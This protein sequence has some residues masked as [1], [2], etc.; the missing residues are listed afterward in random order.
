[1]RRMTD[2]AQGDL[3]QTDRPTENTELPRVPYTAFYSQALRTSIR[4]MSEIELRI[5]VLLATYANDEGVCWPGIRE[6]AEQSGYRAEDVM[7]ALEC[8]EAAGK[9][10][11]LRRSHRDPLTRQM[12]PNVYAVNPMLVKAPNSTSMSEFLLIMEQFQISSHSRNS[13]QNHQTRISKAASSNQHQQAP[14]PTSSPVKAN[15][16]DHAASSE[17]AAG[18][19]NANAADAAPQ[20]GYAQSEHGTHE[21]TRQTPNSARSATQQSPSPRSAPPPPADLSAYAAPLPDD[22]YEQWSERLRTRTGNMSAPNARY[23]VS[24]YG[25]AKVES[26]LHVLGKQPAGEVGNP[27]GYVISLLRKTAVDPQVDTDYNDYTT[28]ENAAFF[29]QPESKSEG[30]R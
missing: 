30:E 5:F 24:T 29:S 17:H 1:M 12:T 8:L 21:P 6:L 23:L 2:Q 4:Q 11:F 3:T 16:R 10:L 19:A 9:L 22:L 18:N 14:P 26:A 25:L 13:N 28:G 15:G 27:A 20:L 7:A